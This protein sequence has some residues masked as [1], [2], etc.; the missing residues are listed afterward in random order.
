MVNEADKSV[1]GRVQPLPP[2][3]R[4]VP[5][6]I[7]PPWS[8]AAASG[9][10]S[11][12]VVIQF[13]GDRVRIRDSKFVHGSTLT[14]AVQPVVSV[15]AKAWPAFIDAVAAGA[16]GADCPE[17]GFET[18]ASGH[19]VVRAQ[20]TGLELR[21]EA[22]EWAAFVDGARAGEFGPVPAVV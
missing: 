4:V 9:A 6:R 15:T 2:S 19:V 10:T 21:F 16:A 3:F 18:V 17:I 14:G 22:H 1:P 8:K 13:L 11:A 7:Q 12:C 5:G 20:A